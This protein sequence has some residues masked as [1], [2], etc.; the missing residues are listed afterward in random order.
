MPPNPVDQCGFRPRRP[1]DEFQKVHGNL[2]EKKIIYD[3]VL[4]FFFC[5]CVCVVVVVVV[6]VTCF[7]WV[8]V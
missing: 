7:L 2:R 6:V 5:V 1:R 8:V 4:L 3:H